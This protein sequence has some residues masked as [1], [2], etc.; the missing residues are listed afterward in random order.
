MW[1]CQCGVSLHTQNAWISLVA[2]E[3]PFFLISDLSMIETGVVVQFVVLAVM[4]I[5]NV[6]RM[7]L[8]MLANYKIPQF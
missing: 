6:Y 5:E 1:S 7:E 3:E 4:W 2:G 8:Q